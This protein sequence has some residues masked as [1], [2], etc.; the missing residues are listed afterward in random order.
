MCRA[1]AAGSAANGGE[2]ETTP[3]TP[4]RHGR[5]VGSQGERGSREVSGCNS[6][7]KTGETPMQPCN[8]GGLN[9]WLEEDGTKKR[10]LADESERERARATETALSPPCSDFCQVAVVQ[11]QGPRPP[12]AII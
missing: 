8:K 6:G 2:S 11:R 3:A 7:T 9:P 1:V 5:L 4:G 12:A 10:W